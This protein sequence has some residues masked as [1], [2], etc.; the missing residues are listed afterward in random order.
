MISWTDRLAGFIA[1]CIAL[2]LIGAIFGSFSYL[3]FLPWLAE[4]APQWSLAMFGVSLVCLVLGL[5]SYGAAIVGDNRVVA[6]GAEAGSCLS[7]SFCIKCNRV[8][9][10]RAHHC[11]TCQECILRM[12]HH[13][14]WINNCVG[15]NNHGH[16]LR[17]LAYC[18]L[19]I[20]AA[21][22][23]MAGRLGDLYHLNS[24]DR[25]VELAVLV[26]DLI[27]CAI[28]SLMIGVLA[29]VQC[30]NAVIGGRTTIEGVANE[31]EYT[32]NKGWLINGKAVFG[33]YVLLWP[34]PLP[35]T[36][37]PLV[38]DEDAKNESMSSADQQ[39]ASAPQK[40]ITNR[41]QHSRYRQGSA[42][43]GGGF[44]VPSPNYTINVENQMGR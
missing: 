25:A 33:K 37:N 38:L 20:L 1:I 22:A 8:R 41:P 24:I 31:T 30:S 13:C 2:L 15:A 34:L 14:P 3:I 12:D 10:A 36:L 19:G 28:L 27:S 21:L 17:F 39:S 7:G 26:A 6:G 43:D 4:G 23:L 29:V 35:L 44:I 40:Q 32:N 9:P 11:S 5:W 16:Y 42:D 18:L